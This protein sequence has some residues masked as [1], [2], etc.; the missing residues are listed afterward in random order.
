MTESLSTPVPYDLDGFADYVRTTQLPVV[1]FGASL[2]GEVAVEQL[3]SKGIAVDRFCDNDK[4]KVGHPFCGIEVVSAK[5][6][7]DY[8][9]DAIVLI[10]TKYILD[11]I[12]QLRDAVGR[13]FPRGEPGIEFF[14]R[15]G[16]DIWQ[17]GPH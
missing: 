2:T 5:K 6:L 12:E 4:M 17:H 3:Q 7:A 10:T 15:Q 9:Q 14:A 1:I 8:Y 16:F 11:A 13:Q